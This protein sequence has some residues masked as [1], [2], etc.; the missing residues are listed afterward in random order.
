MAVYVGYQLVIIS[1]C[2]KTEGIVTT[3]ETVYGSAHTK[4]G[5]AKVESA[6][7][8]ISYVVNGKLYSMRG[9]ENVLFGKNEIVPVIYVRTNPTKAFVYTF[10]S[11]WFH[12]ILVLPII[13]LGAVIIGI[14]KNGSY[15]TL[16][17]KQPHVTRIEIQKRSD[18]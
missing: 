12:P 16:Y 5:H 18:D 7:P 3:Y 14:G 4:Y 11:F 10:A 15:W 13:I 9:E 6:Y 2:D 17:L 1:L 8:V